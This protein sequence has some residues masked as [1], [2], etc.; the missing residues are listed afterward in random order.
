MPGGFQG[1]TIPCGIGTPAAATG[2]TGNGPTEGS[3]A[4]LIAASAGDRAD[5]LA[6]VAGQTDRQPAPVDWWISPGR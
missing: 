2:M 1:V 6:G 4:S 3:M 5:E